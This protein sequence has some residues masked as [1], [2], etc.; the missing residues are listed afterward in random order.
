MSGKLKRSNTI[1]RESIGDWTK[2][3]DEQVL[4]QIISDME[5]EDLEMAN[6]AQPIE[7]DYTTNSDCFSITFIEFA[8]INEYFYETFRKSSKDLIVSNYGV[9]DTVGRISFGGPFSI[10]NPWWFQAKFPNDKNEYIFQTKMYMDNRRDIITE[11]HIAVKDG[12]S[13]EGLVE[14]LRKVKSLAF[15]NSKYTGKCI[16]VKLRDGSFRGIEIIDITNFSTELVL[17]ETQNKFIDHFVNRVRR[18]GNARYLLNGEPGT[19]KTESIRDIIRQLTPDV[20]F[21]MPDFTTSD[22]LTV[23]L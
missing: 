12:V 7:E 2:E 4:L 21:V 13:S 22:D 20:T 1:Q 9:T 18:G 5:Q 16:K 15:N 10:S 6:E 8:I 19:G 17:S 14:I 23:I 11:L 3:E